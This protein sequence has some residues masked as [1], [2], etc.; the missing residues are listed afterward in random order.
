MLN[1]LL[2][3]L[4]LSND[5]GERERRLASDEVVWGRDLAQ[6]HH[7][8]VNSRRSLV[9]S[10]PGDAGVGG[11]GARWKVKDRMSAGRIG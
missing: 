7:P 2:S 10:T 8:S 6:H 5:E 1:S 3:L 9:C 4:F 11:V